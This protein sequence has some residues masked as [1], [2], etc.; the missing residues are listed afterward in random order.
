MDKGTGF[1]PA[2]KSGIIGCVLG[3]LT[4]GG[5]N[6]LLAALP[7][8]TLENVLGNAMSGAIAGFFGGFMGLFSWIRSQ[9]KASAP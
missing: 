3:A 5:F 2:F 6:Y 4:S 8:T 9:R 1:S 7:Q